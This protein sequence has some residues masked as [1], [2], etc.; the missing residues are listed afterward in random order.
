MT[1]ADAARPLRTLLGVAAV[2]VAI[3]VLTG[4][5]IWQVERLGW[6]NGV[7]RT[8]EARLAAPPEDLAAMEARFAAA[9]DVDYRPVRVAGRFLH[10]GERH[11]LST[12][13]GEAGWNIYTPLRLADGRILFVN[14]GFVPYAL[15][16]P[17]TRAA[18]A[19]E[20]PVEVVGLARNALGEKP[21]SFTPDNDPAA[22]NYYWKSLP[23]MER[24]AGLPAGAAV[25]PFIVDAGPGRAPGGW[26][27]GG[28]TV[29]DVPN[30]HLQYAV[31]WFGLAAA[32]AAMVLAR[33][34][35]GLGKARAP[36]QP[37]GGTQP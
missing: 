31:T 33:L 15:K 8:I 28:T 13:D 17:A 14:R 24:G 30:N 36:V 22:N 32:L 35:R 4:L 7:I 29:V 6:K 21:G 3:A 37:G 34:F 25:V 19:V 11:F 12:F 2:A 5:G 10:A 18:G 20:G 1:S 9:G 23:D 27:V 16:D 26:P